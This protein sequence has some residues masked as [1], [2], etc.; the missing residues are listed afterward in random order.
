MR[1]HDANAKMPRLGLFFS[2][3]AACEVV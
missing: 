2:F 1:K 3:L